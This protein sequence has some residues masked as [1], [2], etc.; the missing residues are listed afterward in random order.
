MENH[1]HSEHWFRINRPE[2][3]TFCEAVI[4]HI[5]NGYRHISIKAEVKVGK[6]EIVECLRILL[7]SSYVLLYATALNRKD[8]KNQQTELEKYKITTHVISSENERTRCIACLDAILE[9]NKKPV[10][11]LDEDDHGTGSRQ[12]LAPLSQ[13]IENNANVIKLYTSAT[14]EELRNSSIAKRS[15]YTSINFISPP[16]H[17]GAKYFLDNGLVFKPQSAFT[18]KVSPITLSEHGKHVLEDSVTIERNIACVRITGNMKAFKCSEQSIIGNLN[19]LV[20]KGGRPWGVVFIDGD[21]PFGWEKIE[22]LRGY[23]GKPIIKNY[24]FLFL[25][26]CTRS[27]DLKGWHPYIACWHDARPA[28]KS[29]YNTLVQALLRPSH[30]STMDGYNGSQPIRI[31]ADE[32]VF[33]A[34][35]TGDMDK[36]LSEGGKAPLRTKMK[37]RG[38]P[39]Q[40]D[41]GITWKE[42]HESQL[43][44]ENHTQ[45]ADGFYTMRVRSKKEQKKESYAAF[46]EL[47]KDCETDKT[48]MGSGQMYTMKNGDR[49]DV[50]FISYKDISD[51]SSI[52]IEVATLTRNKVTETEKNTVN[53]T[54]R[55]MYK[56]CEYPS[57][58]EEVTIPTTQ[59]L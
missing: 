27:T 28:N 55:S 45:D 18:T 5:L 15:D 35:V 6:K 48:W 50:T 7:D 26:T 4:Q 47:K 31:Y 25:Q 39:N 8:V 21:N 24:L 56:T 13:S 14:P 22:I 41:W 36:Y 9:L 54:S 38:D 49:R 20:C 52:H 37:K 29:S 23:T 46:L 11:I 33:K 53:T 57:N 34:V 10:Y 30:Y 58:V 1:P 19:A 40:S 12:L 43:V 42:I 16:Q 51:P 59:N 32:R 2:I 17:R 44:R 3:Y